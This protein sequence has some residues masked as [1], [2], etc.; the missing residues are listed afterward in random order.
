MS[1]GPLTD[2]E[3]LPL[4]HGLLARHGST[5]IFLFGPDGAPFWAARTPLERREL[6]TLEKALELIEDTENKIRRPFIA[7]DPAEAFTV[8]AL[9]HRDDLYLVVVAE[10]PSSLAAEARVA[11]VRKSLEPVADRLRERVASGNVG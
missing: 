8:A 4:L 2:Q 1:S 11:A 3:L 6:T 10:D 9:D 7:R 5:Q